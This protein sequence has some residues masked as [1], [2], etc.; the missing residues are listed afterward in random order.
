MPKT[1]NKKDPPYYKTEA[2][3]SHM[4][5]VQTY[6]YTSAKEKSY[7]RSLLY[8][9]ISP[10]ISQAPKYCFHW[11]TWESVS[12]LVTTCNYP[13]VGTCSTIMDA[14]YPWFTWLGELPSVELV[15]SFVFQYHL[16]L[17]A[18]Q[19]PPYLGYIVLL[20]IWSR[21]VLITWVYMVSLTLKYP[22]NI[23]PSRA[24]QSRYP[25]VGSLIPL[26]TSITNI[27]QFTYILFQHWNLL[28]KKVFIPPPLL[29]P[30]LL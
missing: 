8:Q 6:D 10:F 9:L 1:F 22:T 19:E 14:S 3:P 5:R 26:L 2:S 24:L 4:S 21:I 12:L 25:W 17:H 7:W 29:A 27:M 13:H 20:S 15:P 18:M 28:P 30:I 23:N 16:G 11:T